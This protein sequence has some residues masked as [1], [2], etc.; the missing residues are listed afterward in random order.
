MFF[1]FYR[2]WPGLTGFYRVFIVFNGIDWISSGSTASYWTLEV[3]IVRTSF[4]WFLQDLTF[5][6]QSS[7]NIF[8][9]NW[10]FFFVSDRYPARGLHS[11]AAAS[12]AAPGRQR[13]HA[14]A[15]LAPVALFGDAFATRCEALPSFGARFPSRSCR[16]ET[17][18][19]S[20]DSHAFQICSNEVRLYIYDQND[21]WLKWR[22]LHFQH[23]LHQ[24][25]WF[26]K[27]A[28]VRLQNMANSNRF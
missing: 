7:R 25:N 24:W 27:V 12:R 11:D 18:S 22:A 5:V 26:I 3:F 17:F 2:V 15:K 16:F 13:L 21:F 10:V 14:V 19:C 28:S 23:G 6:I 4:D 1:G 8:R 20:N 9:R